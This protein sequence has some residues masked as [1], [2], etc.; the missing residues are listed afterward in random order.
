MI[1]H[2]VQGWEEGSQLPPSRSLTS[3]VQGLAHQGTYCI[4]AP[5]LMNRRVWVSVEG[6]V[7]VGGWVQ[8]NN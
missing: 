8:V 5:P 1:V 2:Y 7:V 4:Q 3:R 6:W